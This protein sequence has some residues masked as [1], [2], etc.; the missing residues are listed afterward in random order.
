MDQRAILLPGFFM[1]DQQSAREPVSVSTVNQSASFAR[2][3][4]NIAGYTGR[5]KVGWDKLASRAPAHRGAP[6]RYGTP[7]CVLFSGRS[8]LRDL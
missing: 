7:R 4:E 2:S 6:C 1:I 8:F 5:A 3:L